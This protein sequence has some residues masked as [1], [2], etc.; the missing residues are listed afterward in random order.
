[1]LHAMPHR[2]VRSLIVGAVVVG[3]LGAIEGIAEAQY[4]FHG[5][6]GAAPTG[7]GGVD[8]ATLAS[9]S[10]GRAF[11]H[12]EV[13]VGAVTNGCG[14]KPGQLWPTLNIGVGVRPTISGRYS[15]FM[16]VLNLDFDVYSLKR[17]LSGE[18]SGDA[19]LYLRPGFMAGMRVARF[20]STRD[21]NGKILKAHAVLLGGEVGGFGG[22]GAYGLFT[23]TLTPVYFR[24]KSP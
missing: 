9:L 3:C 15:F 12:G 8:Q 5:S 21:Q 23:V 18:T 11:Q 16:F 14:D 24:D 19:F 13:G 17:D 22:N 7:C 6:V 4:V 2:I 20:N 10:I 1:M